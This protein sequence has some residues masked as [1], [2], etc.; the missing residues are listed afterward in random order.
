MIEFQELLVAAV[1]DVHV[2]PSDEV[3]TAVLVDVVADTATRR[4]FP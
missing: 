2:I 3:I 4:L 1:R